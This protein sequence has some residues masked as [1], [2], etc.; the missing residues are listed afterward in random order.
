MCK[1]HFGSLIAA[2][3]QGVIL[4]TIVQGFEVEGRLFIGGSFS[5]L[6][7]FSITTGIALIFGYVL[8]GATWWFQPLLNTATCV[9]QSESRR[10]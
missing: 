8:L 9:S 4:G 1:F 7:A 6:S 5:W 3:F 2:F 10:A